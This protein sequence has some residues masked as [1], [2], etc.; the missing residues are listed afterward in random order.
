MQ[1]AF[2][3]IDVCEVIID[4]CYEWNG[5]EPRRGSY[6]FWLRT[7]LVC[8]AWLPRSR[9]NLLREVDL[10]NESHVSLLQ[11]TLL[12]APHL[13]ELVV[14]LT[15]SAE[16]T[17]FDC[18]VALATTPLP[19]ML[20]NCVNIELN[21]VFWQPFPRRYIHVGLQPWDRVQVLEIKLC[22]AGLRQAMYFVWSLPTLR[23]L[24]LTC[25]SITAHSMPR[26]AP[27]STVRK[28]GACRVLESLILPSV[29]SGR[30][31]CTGALR[32]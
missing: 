19:R 3:P 4:S 26:A 1:N 22:P 6:P 8:S 18:V 13:A 25:S 12:A 32:D 10:E 14:R 29:C 31:C 21:T 15:C 16:N 23:K 30:S 24:Y 17:H 5:G 2:L 27:L 9:F 20:K 7:A 11:R 28:P